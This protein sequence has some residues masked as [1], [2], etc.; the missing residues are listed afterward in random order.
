MLWLCNLRGSFSQ[1]WHIY[2]QGQGDVYS[3]QMFQSQCLLVYFIYRTLHFGFNVRVFRSNMTVE[4]YHTVWHDWVSYAQFMTAKELLRMS[5]LIEI[6]GLPNLIFVVGFLYV[7]VKHVLAFYPYL[8]KIRVDLVNI[9]LE[10]EIK[11]MCVNT[12]ELEPLI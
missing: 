8:C 3:G 2:T 6:S 12:V 10:C 1:E 5:G 11:K 7:F 4:R 9:S